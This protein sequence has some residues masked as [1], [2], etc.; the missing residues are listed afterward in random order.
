MKTREQSAKEL[1]AKLVLSHDGDM[2][3]VL[4]DISATT[5]VW[6]DAGV[7]WAVEATAA[8]FTAY[9][10]ALEEQEGRS[11]EKIQARS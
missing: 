5:K 10:D 2:P 3:A 9:T 8:V 6:L 4:K 1:M 7:P 11:H